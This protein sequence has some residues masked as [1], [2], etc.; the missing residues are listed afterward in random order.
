MSIAAEVGL[1]E[2]AK[3]EGGLVGYLA[4]SAADAVTVQ[5]SFEKKFPQIKV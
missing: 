4:M 3:D 5:S 1:R 2:K